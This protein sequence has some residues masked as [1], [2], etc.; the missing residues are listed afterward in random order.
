MSR[1]ANPALIGLF[2]IGAIVIG[3]GSLILLGGRSLFEDKTTCVT[4]FDENI[5]GLDIGARVELGGVRVG[6]VTDIRI[7]F[8]ENNREVRRPVTFQLEHSRFSLANGAPQAKSAALLDAI[9]QHGLRT[10]VATD[11]LLTGKLKVNLVFTP[12]APPALRNAGD[13]GK[14]VEVP[15]IPSPFST[16]VRT[17][18]D[19]PLNEIISDIHGAVKAGERALDSTAATTSNLTVLVQNLN[20]RLEPLLVNLNRV[21]ENAER[22]TSPDSD[23][24]SE[25]RAALEEV[26]A[27]ARS[28]R[29]FSD[30]ASRHP[31]SLMKGKP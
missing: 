21:A 20:D 4:Y 18:E 23:L 17:A 2:V 5:A 13:A 10:Q 11:N 12:P 27:A 3:A 28:V 22:L 15:S 9:G 1:K 7:V 31:E 6:T 30:Y 8:D 25:T 26:K 29:E 14:A 16:L 24:Q 19:L